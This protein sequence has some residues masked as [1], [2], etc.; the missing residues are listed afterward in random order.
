MSSGKVTVFHLL[1]G[2]GEYRVM[3]EAVD[4]PLYIV[5]QVVSLILELFG[6]PGVI[7]YAGIFVVAGDRVE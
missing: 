7:Q 2:N 1:V 6:E 4:D 5:V 3:G